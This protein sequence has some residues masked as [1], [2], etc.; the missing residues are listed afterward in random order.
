MVVRGGQTLCAWAASTAAARSVRGGQVR[1]EIISKTP[2]VHPSRASRLD[3][4]MGLS[5]RAWI[6]LLHARAFSV[7]HCRSAEVAIDWTD[8]RARRA[9]IASFR[10]RPL[11]P[12]RWCISLTQPTS[13]FILHEAPAPVAKMS[14]SVRMLPLMQSIPRSMRAWSLVPAHP[15]SCH[16]L[17]FVNWRSAR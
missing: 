14:T 9:W 11:D 10:E 7:S 1:S 3:L 15:A 16:L 17:W 8:D 5:A 6:P 12:C 13:T 4:V 2:K